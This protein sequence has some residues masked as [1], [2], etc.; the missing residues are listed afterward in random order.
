[1]GFTPNYLAALSS[2]KSPAKFFLAIAIL[3]VPVV[4]MLNLDPKISY[5]LVG[6]TQP[7]TVLFAS[8][9]NFISL[10]VVGFF[11]AY[12]AIMVLVSFA[13]VL[14]TPESYYH[15]PI[16]IKHVDFPVI[17]NKESLMMFITEVDS[18]TSKG[19]VRMPDHHL[20]NM[21]VDKRGNL[22]NED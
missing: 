14:F 19:Q 12:L 8:N 15:D 13:G 22:L 2:I 5:T 6:T 9:L 10:I 17:P 21:N 18:L 16:A 11:L 1:M 3:S 7:T 20:N 4:N